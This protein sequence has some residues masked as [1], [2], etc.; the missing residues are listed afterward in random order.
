[1]MSC[2]VHPPSTCCRPLEMSGLKPIEMSSFA[3]R[4][5]GH[6]Y[7]GGRRPDCDEPARAGP[8]AGVAGRQ[9]GAVRAGQGGRVAQAECA[10]VATFARTLVK[11]RA[12]GTGP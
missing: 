12:N 7:G 1:M 10:P 6:G 9:G 5:G 3:T 8:F 4:Q 2:L 11:T